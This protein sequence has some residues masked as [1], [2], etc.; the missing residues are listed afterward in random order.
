MPQEMA[1]NGTAAEMSRMRG[2]GLGTQYRT[3]RTC[4]AITN[5]AGSL[6][7]KDAK[8]PSPF[9]E[10][11]LALP[12][13]TIPRRA[14][15]CLVCSLKRAAGN[16]LRSS[17]LPSTAIA[18]PD[19]TLLDPA[20]LNRSKPFLLPCE[21]SRGTRRFLC[22]RLQLLPDP[23]LPCRATPKLAGA[24]LVYSPKRAAEEPESPC[25]AVCNR[26][27][28]SPDPAGPCH[29]T[30]NRSLPRLICPPKRAAGNTEV[31]LAA[32]C[33]CRR[34]P[35]GRTSPCQTSLFL[36]SPYLVYPLK[37]AAEGA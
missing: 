28:A 2:R 31:L 5:L 7:G 21:S 19:P 34:T 12:C 35:P 29:N 6:G 22:C 3:N 23:A 14:G 25:A 33:N 15:P 27:L 24:R 30:P 4:Q 37:R 17:V 10:P 11:H 26:S 36:A 20:S 13:I 9:T 18:M 32:V 1:K 8:A 16:F